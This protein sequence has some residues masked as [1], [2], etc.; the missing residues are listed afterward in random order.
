METLHHL[1]HCFLH[2]DIQHG[3]YTTHALVSSEDAGAV[4]HKFDDTP[5]VS[6]SILHPNQV[7]TPNAYLLFYRLR[8]PQASPTFSTHRTSSNESISDMDTDSDSQ[9]CMKCMQHC[10]AFAVCF[11]HIKHACT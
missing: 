4:W 11:P 3:H 10:F 9:V 8:T 2:T 5:E 7:I 6:L 1:L